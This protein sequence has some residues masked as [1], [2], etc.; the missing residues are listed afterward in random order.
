MER[1]GR[2]MKVFLCTICMKIFLSYI[3]YDHSS[4]RA[5]HRATEGVAYVP[6]LLDDLESVLN[7]ALVMS[8]VL[9][10]EYFLQIPR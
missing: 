6:L 3:S 2:D 8:T 5:I 10:M 7:C 4:Y 1:S 9:F